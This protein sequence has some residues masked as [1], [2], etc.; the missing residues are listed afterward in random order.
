M[1][2]AEEAHRLSLHDHLRPPGWQ[3][4]P[5]YLARGLRRR[6][7]THGPA[8]A[9]G[10][11]RG[12]RWTPTVDLLANPTAAGEPIAYAGRPTRTGPARK[13]AATETRRRSRPQRTPLWRTRLLA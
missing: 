2:A 9:A 3:R 4:R 8:P 6:W 13:L 12:A 1:T 11:R 7:A 5:R 10:S